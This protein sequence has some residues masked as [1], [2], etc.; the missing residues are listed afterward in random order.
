MAIYE[1]ND[2]ALQYWPCHDCQNQNLSIF[3]LKNNEL[4]SEKNHNP[5]H[6]HTFCIIERSFITNFERKLEKA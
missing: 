2:K 6:P 4:T 1:M 3:D 5:P